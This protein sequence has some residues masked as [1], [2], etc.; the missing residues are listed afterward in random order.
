MYLTL[1][2]IKL[3]DAALGRFEHQTF[4]IKNHSV[5]ASPLTNQLMSAVSHF[6]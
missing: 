4:D 3:Q 2:R 5:T 1:L 6:L